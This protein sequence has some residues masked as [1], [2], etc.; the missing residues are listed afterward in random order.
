MWPSAFSGWY[1]WLCLQLWLKIL[2]GSFPDF[3]FSKSLVF[4]AML[5]ISDSWKPPINIPVERVFPPLFLFYIIP[6][7]NFLVARGLKLVLVN[8]HLGPFTLVFSKHSTACLCCIFWFKKHYLPQLGC[9][10]SNKCH[11]FDNYIKAYNLI[12]L[13]SLIVSLHQISKS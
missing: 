11:L 2:I 9:L 7:S 6:S 12:L 3:F 1:H 4:G 8:C 13:F 5:P 10:L